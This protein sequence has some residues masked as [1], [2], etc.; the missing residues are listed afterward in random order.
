VLNKALLLPANFPKTAD[1]PGSNAPPRR[2]P[3]AA[4]QGR[5][6]GEWH[7]Q[8][9]SAQEPSVTSSSSNRCSRAAASTS[10]DGVDGTAMR[11]G[12]V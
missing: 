12:I 6:V 10:P 8:D 3:F 5:R 4:I 9:R 1:A 2:T 7:K 11:S